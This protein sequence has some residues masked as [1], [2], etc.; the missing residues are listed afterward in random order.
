KV[1]LEV[2]LRARIEGLVRG[3]EDSPRRQVDRARAMSLAD[4]HCRIVRDTR[5]IDR[6]H[7][8]LPTQVA[9][10]SNDAQPLEIQPPRTPEIGELVRFSASRAWPEL[11]LARQIL[12]LQL[13]CRRKQLR[14]LGDTHR[15]DELER[16]LHRHVEV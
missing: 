15:D 1:D 4:F 12:P 3:D 6:T 13:C 11:Q 2:Y 9:F 14:L 5:R 7:G 8:T 10:H 16:L